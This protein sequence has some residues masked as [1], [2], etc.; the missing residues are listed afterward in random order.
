MK[1][2][3]SHLLAMEFHR[4]RL[5]AMRAAI[6]DLIR[7]RPPSLLLNSA[8][9]ITIRTRLDRGLKSAPIY[10]IIGRP[11]R[12][13]HLDRWL[14]PA[15]VNAASSRSGAGQA[16]IEL[17]QVAETYFVK[18]GNRRVA[19]ARARGQLFLL[20][21]VT[22]CIIDGMLDDPADMYTQLLNE[23]YRDFQATTGLAQIR[24][25]QQIVCTA[26]GGYSELLRQIEAHR[27]ELTVRLGHPIEFH[28]AVASWYDSLYLPVIAALR[29]QRVLE[30]LPGRGEADLYLWV[31][32]R[33]I[34]PLAETIAGDSARIAPPDSL[35]RF[36]AGLDCA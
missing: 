14:A 33:S 29:H 18:D 23:E 21:R 31:T 22:E 25:A 13:D 32:N 5:G 15:R 16:L 28:V 7:H 27:A 20:A 10:Q 12:Y 35:L 9:H 11:A 4:A 34:H 8:A 3:V 36:V 19:E 24:P 6:D 2:Q 26:L 30:E 1:D 17:Y